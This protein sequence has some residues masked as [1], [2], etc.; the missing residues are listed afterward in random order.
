[1]KPLT[2][3][4]FLFIAISC[5]IIANSL[6][7]MSDG[8]SKLTPSVA[9]ILLMCVTMFSLAKGMSAIPVGFAYATYRLLLL[10]QYLY[11]ELLNIIKCQ[12]CMV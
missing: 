4:I 10:H 6:A 5:G 11:L 3:Y 12:T 9:C 7:K 1:M 8:F 2:G